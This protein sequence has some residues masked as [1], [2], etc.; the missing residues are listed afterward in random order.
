MNG[1]A[2]QNQAITEPLPRTQCLR[3]SV[4][5]RVQATL[6]TANWG[7]SS[8]SSAD[9]N[10]DERYLKFE[11]EASE[12]TFEGKGTFTGRFSART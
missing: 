5:S 3:E 10:G 1:G 4:L 7:S 2:G 8:R 12:R 11:V 9:P 6:P